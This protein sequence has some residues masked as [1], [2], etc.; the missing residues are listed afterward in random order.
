M[1]NQLGSDIYSGVAA[2]GKLKSGF[3]FFIVSVISLAFVIIGGYLAFRKEV[4]TKKVNGTITKSDCSIYN[5]KYS[6]NLEIKYKVNDTEYVLN[7]IS[8]SNTNKLVVGKT[9]Y[10]Y[11]NEDNHADATIDSGYKKVGW[12]M[13]SIALVVWISTGIHFYF[14]L[15]NNDY[16]A[17]TGATDAS[18][19]FS[20]TP[21]PFTGFYPY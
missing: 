9:I 17:Y 5:K 15:K 13:L 10:V 3:N 12:I 16:A 7:A 11:V 20:R 14:S 6:C 21:L 19:L 2:Y 4:Y 18:N 8:N 1:S